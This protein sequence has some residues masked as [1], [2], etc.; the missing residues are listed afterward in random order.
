MVL[1]ILLAFHFSKTRRPGSLTGSV[2]SMTALMT[3]KIALLPPMPR[4]S[5]ITVMAA[6]PGPL[7]ICRNE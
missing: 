3:P 4:A 2:R 1:G 6:N 7:R 5:V